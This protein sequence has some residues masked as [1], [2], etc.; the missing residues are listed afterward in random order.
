MLV[1]DAQKGKK[2]LTKSDTKACLAIGNGIFNR[3]DGRIILGTKIVPG[4]L[5]CS[6]ESFMQLY[7]R[8]N[9][10]MRR[11]HDITLTITER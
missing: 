7:D 2:S 4:C 5:K 1:N 3:K 8:I 6:R 10:S 11:G 9:Q